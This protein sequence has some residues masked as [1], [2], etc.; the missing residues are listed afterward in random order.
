LPDDYIDSSQDNLS[1]MIISN[2]LQLMEIF[3]IKR[4]RRMGNAVR[5]VPFQGVTTEDLETT[6]THLRRLITLQKYDLFVRALNL[7]FLAPID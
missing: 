2:V 3:N 6:V 4:Y 5:F 1:E 7:H